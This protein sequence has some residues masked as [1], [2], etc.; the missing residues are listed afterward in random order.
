MTNLTHLQCPRLILA[1]KLKC[2]KANTVIRILPEVL[3]RH[4]PL[5][6]PLLFSITPRNPSRFMITTFL[7]TART[8][9]KLRAHLLHPFP[10]TL[11]WP[12]MRALPL[13]RH[14]SVTSRV[15]RRRRSALRLITACFTPSIANVNQM[16]ADRFSRKGR[17]RQYSG[18]ESEER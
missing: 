18:R 8:C 3:V 4:S 17:R 12:R 15:Q 6:L 9:T 1:L 2:L 10:C 11:P 14:D 7:R 5:L 16:V 13:P